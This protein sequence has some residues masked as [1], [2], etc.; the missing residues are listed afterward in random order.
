MFTVR[1]LGV[2]D[3]LARTLTSTNPVESMISIARTHDAQRQ[4]LEGR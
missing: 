2:S 1:R 3:R 4:A